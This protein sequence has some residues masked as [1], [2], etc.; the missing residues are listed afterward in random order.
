MQSLN[1]NHKDDGSSPHQKQ[2]VKKGQSKKGILLCIPP[3]FALASFCVMLMKTSCGPIEGEFTYLRISDAAA[4]NPITAALEN[5]GLAARESLGF[6]KDIPDKA[7][8]RHKKRFQLTQPNVD[9]VQIERKARHPVY[10][11]AANFEPEFTCPHEFRLGKLGDGGKWACD[12]HRILEDIGTADEEHDVVKK[13]YINAKGTCLVYSVGSNGHY[14]FET[15]VLNHVSPECEIHTFDCNDNRRGKVF[16]APEAEKIG[17][18]FHHYGVGKRI[19]AQNFK[20]FTEIAKDLGHENR[21]VDLMKIDCEHCEYEQYNDWLVDWKESGFLVRQIMLEIHGAQYPEVVN[22][23]KVFQDAGYV[24]FHKEANYINGA[25]SVEVAW[26]L[27]SKDF[28]VEE[29]SRL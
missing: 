4:T 22:I 10:F 11:W 17:V 8:K 12:P 26:I 23:F 19:Y 5:T 20:N 29:A 6:F 14:Q 18:K 2:E 24:L 1:R 21:V 7:W 9:Y 16:F 25:N 28:Q 3:I 13:K 27:L 15:E